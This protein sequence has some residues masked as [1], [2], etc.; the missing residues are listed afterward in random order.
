[1]NSYKIEKPDNLH[2]HPTNHWPFNM[3]LD[4][5]I[6]I[7]IQHPMAWI[8]L[9]QADRNFYLFSITPY[10]ITL[11]SK[12]FAVIYNDESGLA[13]NLFGRR[14]RDDDL[15]AQVSTSG[16]YYWYRHGKLHRDTMPAVIDRNGMQC[17]YRNGMLHRDDD[18]PAVINDNGDRHW[19]QN[20]KKHRDN[21]LPAVIYANGRQFWYNDGIFIR[22]PSTSRCH[23]LNLNTQRCQ[24][25]AQ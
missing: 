2:I 19:H 14:H 4:I 17:W 13:Y 25:M 12:Y 3:Q 24:L 11:R 6:Q 23:F 20:G 21:D 10:G 15:P 7:A 8:R 1:M 5:K 9:V 18:E 16:S 22:W